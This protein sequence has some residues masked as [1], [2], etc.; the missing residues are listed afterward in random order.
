MSY[1]Y[2]PFVQ[3][4]QTFYEYTHQPQ[5]TVI[6]AGYSTGYGCTGNT[7]Y[8]TFTETS[9]GVIL[10]TLSHLHSFDNTF[11]YSLIS[12]I[13]AELRVKDSLLPLE[14][15]DYFVINIVF[16][17]DLPII[18]IKFLDSNGDLETPDF[19]NY[20]LYVDININQNILSA[21]FPSIGTQPPRS[22][23]QNVIRN[24]FFIDLSTPA[25]PTVS[26]PF[27]EV[28]NI[29]DTQ[30]AVQTRYGA[31][32]VYLT[33]NI[34]VDYAILPVTN[35]VPSALTFTV[36]VIETDGVYFQFSMDSINSFQVFI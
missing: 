1:S 35:L 24:S 30:Y 36:P 3:A 4:E 19:D 20:I 31:N 23:L 2:Y 11:D 8:V 27:I 15:T 16:D 7:N 34:V 14:S 10:V 17:P 32:L 18:Q 9:A 26:L 5:L 6:S 29:S 25:T 12:T 13:N 22:C 21:G 28:T 33:G